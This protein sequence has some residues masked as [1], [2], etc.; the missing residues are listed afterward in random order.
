MPTLTESQRLA[1][2]ARLRRG[3][4]AAADSI[5]RRDPGRTELPLSFGQQQLWFIDRF[6]PG[7]GMYNIPLAISVRGLLDH[8]ALTAAVGDLTGRHEALRTR[9]VV[10]GGGVPVQIID[11]P[12]P[13]PVRV[14]DLSDAG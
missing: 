5:E 12:S 2:A 8:S 3:R 4:A 11:P 10:G 1:L 14:I 6:A 9:L 13:V 7:Q